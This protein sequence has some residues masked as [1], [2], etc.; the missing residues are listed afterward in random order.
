MVHLGILLACEHY[1]VVSC[2]PAKLDAQLR[3]WLAGIGYRVTEVSVFNCYLGNTPRSVGDCDIWI[4]SGS[5]VGCD[6]TG[7]DLRGLLLEFL[8]GVAASGR[9]VFA[10]HHGEHLLHAALA[11]PSSSAPQTPVTM[12]VIRNPFR[13]FRQSDTLFRFEVIRRRITPAPRPMALKIA[14]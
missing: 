5:P 13:S 11:S 10:I 14:A 7:L 4:T 3:C 6:A 9:P 8:R 1:P 12:R 2:D